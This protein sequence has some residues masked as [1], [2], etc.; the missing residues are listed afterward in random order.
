MLLPGFDIIARLP[1][2]HIATMNS[3]LEMLAWDFL[4]ANMPSAAA[5]P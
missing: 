5:V 2:G 1:L 4:V 3:Q